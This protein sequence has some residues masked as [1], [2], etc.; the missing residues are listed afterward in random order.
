MIERTMVHIYRDWMKMARIMGIND[1]KTNLIRQLLRMTWKNQKSETDQ[2]KIEIFREDQIRGL[3]NYL[4]YKVK[5]EF[6]DKKL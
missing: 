5:T 1:H 3:S 2:E 6:I 4:V